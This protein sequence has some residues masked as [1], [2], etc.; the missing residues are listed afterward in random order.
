MRPVRIVVATLLALAVP[1][2]VLGAPRSDPNNVAGI[3]DA[4]KAIVAGNQ[5][6]VAKDVPGAI[7]EYKKA[8]KIA[9]KNPLGHFLLGQ[10]QVAS[11]ALP[12]ADASFK[13]ADE[14]GESMPGVKA[15]VLFAIA[16][17]RERQKKW[18]DAKAAWQR[19]IE[20]ASKHADAGAYPQ[21]GQSRISA[22]DEM[23]KQ[24]KQYVTVRERIAADK[25][26]GTSSPVPS[27]TDAGK[28]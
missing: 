24:E 19:Y 8:I 9:P 21:S 5:K 7:E 28:R 13:Q 17:L 6:Y 14:L 18:E 26:G 4:M 1:A 2:V 23:L 12:E 20:F 3:S 22:I 10:A 15:R 16:D 11:N 25:D 27:A